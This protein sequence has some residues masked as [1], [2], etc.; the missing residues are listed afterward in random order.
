MNILSTQYSL[1]YR[2]LEIY[3]AGCKGPHCKGCHN[4]ESWDFNNGKCYYE[5]T[6]LILDKVKTF[7]IMLDNIMVMGGEPMDQNLN[8]LHELLVNLKE[9]GKIIWLFTRYDF[10]EIPKFIKGQCDYI[11]TGRYDETCLSDSYWQEGIQLASTN[12]QIH[13]L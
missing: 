13:K 11:K 1:L 6:E 5:E 9:T 7:D 10:Y 3:I 8:Q 12:Q 2:A 4:K